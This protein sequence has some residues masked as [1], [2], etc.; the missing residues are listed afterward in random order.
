MRRLKIAFV[1]VALPAAALIYWYLSSSEEAKAQADHTATAWKC[2]KC[3]HEFKLTA[4]QANKEAVRAGGS[5]PLFCPSC[6]EKKAY[7][8]AECLVC[9]TKYFSAKVPGS[10]G[11][12]PKCY[13]PQQNKKDKS[14]ERPPEED[15]D[16]DPPPPSA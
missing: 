14:D 9:Q 16:Y 13:P 6:A 10:T 7:R 1:L 4:D 15:P 11:M 5:M 3:E 8:V 12:C 2:I